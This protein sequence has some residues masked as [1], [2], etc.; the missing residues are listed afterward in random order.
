MKKFW[1][2][3]F[4][5]GVVAGWCG[6][7]V[8]AIIYLCLG[9]SGVVQTLDVFQVVLGI[10]SSFVMA[11]VAAGISAVYQI[12]KLP[13]VWATLIQGGVL[14]IDY[15]GVYLLNG[16]LADGIVPILIFTAI[17]IVGFVAIWLIVYFATKCATNKL[18]KKLHTQE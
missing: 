1:E 14:Y 13:L 7:I 17:F 3:F 5:R 18:N 11:F 15:L 9:L 8:L 2:S 4:M 10:V 12:E 16:W 6:P